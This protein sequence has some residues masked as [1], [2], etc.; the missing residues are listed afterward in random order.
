MKRLVFAGAIALSLSFGCQKNTNQLVEQVAK[1]EKRIELLEQRLKAAPQPNA[2]R[3][4]EPQTQALDI[5]LGDSYV[6]GNPKASITL[7]E[8][9]DIQ[10]P[11]CVKAHSE[12]VEKIQEDPELKNK[13]KIV[14]KQ[15]PLNFHKNARPAAKATLAAGEQ[16]ADCFWKMLKVLYSKQKELA[17]EISPEEYKK[18]A[19][20]V[21]CEQNGKVAALNVEKFS[22]DL[23]ANDAKYN[24]M[25]DDDMATGQNKGVRGTPSFYVGDQKGFWKLT[26]QRTVDAVKQVI[27]ERNLN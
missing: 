20:E 23:S 18:W 19:A 8:F 6:W 1:L 17:G 24:K 22:K 12:L 16:S 4:E 5:P 9:S 10:C 11:F 3:Q 13:V 15:F 21:Q 25:I 27:K 2:P 26:G 7:I 14:Y